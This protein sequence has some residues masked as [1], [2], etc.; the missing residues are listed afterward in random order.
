MPALADGQVIAGLHF[1]QA[2]GVEEAVLFA[3]DLAVAVAAHR[4]VLCVADL[5]AQV[6]ADV[7]LP[8]AL[9]VEVDAFGAL[10]VVDVQLVEAFAAGG[11]ARSEHAARLVFR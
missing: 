6:V 2:V 5:Q 7:L 4:L 1:A 8:V 9:G 11:A 10:A 3:L